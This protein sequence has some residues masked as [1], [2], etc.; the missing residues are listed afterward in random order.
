MF[1]DTDLVVISF[2]KCDTDATTFICYHD[3]GNSL[4]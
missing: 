4:R 3:G 2:P 1:N